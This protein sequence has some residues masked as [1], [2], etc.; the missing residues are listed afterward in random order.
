M[1][2]PPLNV[3]QRLEAGG[4]VQP[5]THFKGASA[6]KSHQNKGHSDLL[7]GLRALREV[8]KGVPKTAITASA[9]GSVS[10]GRSWAVGLCGGEIVLSRV[11]SGHLPR[12]W[13][14]GCPKHV[15]TAVAA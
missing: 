2:S 14:S 13:S 11:E 8:V 7:P 3:P 1:A 10:R 15:G 9:Q 12:Q 6:E 5:G 4:C